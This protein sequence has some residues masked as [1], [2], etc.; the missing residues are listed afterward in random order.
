MSSEPREWN[1]NVSQIILGICMCMKIRFFSF[2]IDFNQL[3]IHSFRE[4]NEAK[5]H[6]I[7]K[8]E[9]KRIQVWSRISFQTWLFNF[10]QLILWWHTK[11][12]KRKNHKNY[13]LKK[14]EQEH[15]K[16]KNFISFPWTASAFSLAVKKLGFLTESCKKWNPEEHIKRLIKSLS[17]IFAKWIMKI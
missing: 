6:I 12:H 15:L 17:S 7:L 14:F 4:K 2:R 16:I 11:I 13:L 9:W 3:C 10:T 1:V 5:L 8:Q